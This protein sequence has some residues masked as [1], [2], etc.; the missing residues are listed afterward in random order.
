MK[1]LIGMIDF[2]LK[3][4]EVLKTYKNHDKTP[5]FERCVVY[6]KFLKQPLELWMFDKNDERCLFEGFELK[7]KTNVSWIFNYKNKFP[8]FVNKSANIESIVRYNFQLTPVALKQIG[9]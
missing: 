7:G 3:Q 8:Y 9:L 2:V 6:A 4:N 1:N 5:L